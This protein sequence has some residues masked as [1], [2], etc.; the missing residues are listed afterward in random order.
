MINRADS[1]TQDILPCLHFNEVSIMCCYVKSRTLLPLRLLQR[2]K[3]AF[4]SVDFIKL[5]DIEF[6]HF[7]H[8]LLMSHFTLVVVLTDLKTFHLI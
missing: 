6:G 2:L 7:L 5:G 1:S 4:I 3:K 8:L